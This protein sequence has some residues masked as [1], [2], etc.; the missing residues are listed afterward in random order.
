MKKG[1]TLIELVVVVA[2][3]GILTAASTLSLGNQ[4]MRAR[5]SRRVVDA[6]GL[7]VGIESYRAANGNYPK[8]NSYDEP[9]ETHLGVLVEQGLINTLPKDPKPLASAAPNTTWYNFC[10]GYVYQ[11]PLASYAAEINYDFGNPAQKLG[12][13]QY[14]IYFRQETPP[15]GFN[16]NSFDQSLPEF[17]GTWCEPSPHGNFSILFGPK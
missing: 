16:Q 3:I 11:G 4:R 9:I 13:R 6:G 7:G 1:F 14:G 12:V 8:S 10:K 5:D 17:T 2:I 15:T